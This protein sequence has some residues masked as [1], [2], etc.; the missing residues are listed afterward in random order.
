MSTRANI[1]IRDNYHDTEKQVIYLHSDGYPEGVG[2]DLERIFG[3]LSK[4]ENGR[5]PSLLMDKKIM[6]TAICEQNPDWNDTTPSSAGDAEYIYEIDLERRRVDWQ[7]LS[8]DGNRIEEEY[9][10]NF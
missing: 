2:R 1:F 4:D 10:F 3:L 8:L 6:A 7:H 9:L 5:I